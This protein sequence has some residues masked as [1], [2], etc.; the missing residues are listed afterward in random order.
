[1]KEIITR[2]KQE[3]RLYQI[4]MESDRSA[5]MIAYELKYIKGGFW[6]RQVRKGRLFHQ[7]GEKKGQQVDPPDKT[8]PEINKEYEEDAEIPEEEILQQGDSSNL[9]QKP[10][11][12]T[13]L[14]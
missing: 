12:T 14:L 2:T 10:N 1:S 11:V 6:V 8:L 3:P 7:T 5:F 4:I 9:S 13:K